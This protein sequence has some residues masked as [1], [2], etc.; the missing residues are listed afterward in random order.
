MTFSDLHFNNFWQMSAEVLFLSCRL[1]KGIE[2]I[3]DC[4]FALHPRAN[5]SGQALTSLVLIH[6]ISDSLQQKLVFQNVDKLITRNPR[7]D[8]LIPLT[9]V[10]VSHLCFGCVGRRVA[11]SSCHRSKTRKGEKRRYIL[12]KIAT[13]S[14]E[15][16][17]DING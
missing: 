2:I 13:T 15:S 11:G 16:S 12:R 8:F 6:L 5:S 10:H 14:A 17:S 4:P 3:T 1:S 9:D 7:D